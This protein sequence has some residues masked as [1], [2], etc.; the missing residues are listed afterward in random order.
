MARRTHAKRTHV[1]SVC[2]SIKLPYDLH[3]AAQEAAANEDTSFGEIVRR[4][5]AA[6]LDESPGGKQRKK[7]GRKSK[8]PRNQRRVTTPPPPP[9]AATDERAA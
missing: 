3:V 2:T 6:F 8:G 1:P 7:A 9:A 4:A 5:L